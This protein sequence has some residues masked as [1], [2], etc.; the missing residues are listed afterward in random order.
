L[1]PSMINA[2]LLALVQDKDVDKLVVLL[3]RLIADAKHEVYQ[4]LEYILHHAGVVC[5]TT[6]TGEHR[7]VLLE[8]ANEQEDP[9][10]EGETLQELCEKSLKYLRNCDEPSTD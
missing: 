10:I 5:I 6:W 7:G 3:A 2:E 9:T 8:F 1:S 4:D